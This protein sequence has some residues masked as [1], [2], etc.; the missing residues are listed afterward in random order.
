MRRRHHRRQL[1][2]TVRHCDS[3][4]ALTPCVDVKVRGR[5]YDRLP[6][7]VQDRDSDNEIWNLVVA[8]WWDLVPQELA[9]AHLRPAHPGSRPEVWADGRSGG[10]CCVAGIGVPEDWD[11]RQFA[12]WQAF[13]DAVG[14]SLTEY[15]AVYANTV[16]VNLPV[17]ARATAPHGRCAAEER[18]VEPVPKEERCR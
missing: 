4:G 13:E 7:D 2:A 18:C 6:A 1:S 11:E 16:R 10:W 3:V 12:A 17:A 5:L 8:Q 14:E 15:E 9:D